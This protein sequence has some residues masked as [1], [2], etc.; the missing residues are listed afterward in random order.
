MVTVSMGNKKR[1]FKSVRAMSEATGIPYI[2]LYMRL[3]NGMKPA[4][5]AKKPVRKYVKGNRNVSDHCA[6]G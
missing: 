1:I 3:R 5:A 6:I 2:T 4:T